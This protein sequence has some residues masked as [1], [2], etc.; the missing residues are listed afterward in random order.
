VL[1]AQRLKPA[2]AT[3]ASELKVRPV[4]L[5]LG[6]SVITHKDVPFSANEANIGR[7]AEEIAEARVPQLVIV[8]GGGS[9]GHPL[10]KKYAIKDGFNGKSSQL[11]GF[12]ETHQAMVTL[13]NMIL[14]ALIHCNIPALT[15]APSSIIVSKSGRIVA[16]I[17]ERLKS[18]LHLGLVPL[19]YGDAVLDSDKGFAILSGDQLVASAAI[20]LNAERIV[21]GV[22]GNGLFKSDPKEGRGDLIRT[23]TLR[24]LKELQKK[25]RKTTVHD[26]TGGMQGKIAELIPAVEKGITVVVVN[27][28]K[29]RRV[30]KALR[31]EKVI[32]TII[33]KD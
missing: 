19:L 20:Q 3:K 23:C 11:L 30:Y 24:Q 26:V 28:C 2:K 8:H 21:I 25:V 22:E 17:D 33:R 32:G 14:K 31:G 9:F 15:M 1:V 10:A 5:K 6:G 27:A 29:P 13:N 12:S 16:R 18:L 4:V 7:L